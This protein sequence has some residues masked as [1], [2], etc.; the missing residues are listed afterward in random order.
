MSALAAQ[1]S[2]DFEVIVVD[3]GSQDG[4]VEW[5]DAHAPN[6]RLVRN[7]A[8]LGFAMAN[9][10]GIRASSAPLVAALNNDA[11]PE[12]EW[13]ETLVSAAE[14]APE[15]GMFASKILLRESDG[16]MDSA[17]IEVDR[18]GIAWNRRWGEHDLGEESTC[19]EVFGPSA[20]AAVHRRAILDHIGLFDEDYFI[21][22]ED[23]DLA[24]RAQWAGWRCVY[25]P[26]AVVHHEHSATTVR[27]SPFKN[28]LLGRNNGGRMRRITLFA[29]WRCA[30]QP[31]SCSTCGQCWRPSWLAARWLHCAGD[32]MA[33]VAGV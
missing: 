12:P 33:C 22:Y 1:T 21:Y 18:A 10:Q 32:G 24:W 15:A 7:Q 20:A 2:R 31:W 13:L 25:V 19:V 26:Q 9:N 16:R 23:V 28:Y 14:Q 27:G 3:N 8:N 5:L 17:G 30:S 29:K 11:L 6:V 4:S